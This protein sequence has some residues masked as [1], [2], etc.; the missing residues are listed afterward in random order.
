LILAVLV[1]FLRKSTHGCVSKIKQRIHTILD[2]G[3]LEGVP[4]LLS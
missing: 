3:W 1:I 4:P 2:R